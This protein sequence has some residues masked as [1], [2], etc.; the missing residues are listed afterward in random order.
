MRSIKSGIVLITALILA[1]AFFYAALGIHSALTRPTAQQIAA[2]GQAE[3]NLAAANAIRADTQMSWVLVLAF[4][5]TGL[6]SLVMSAAMTI[7]AIY[8]ISERRRQPYPQQL[9]FEW[10]DIETAP[11]GPYPP[12]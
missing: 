11:I 5:A 9:K 6:G 8:L 3:I 10:G 12:A 1:V 2:Q 4:G 7:L